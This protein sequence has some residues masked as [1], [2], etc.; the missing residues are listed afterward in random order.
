MLGTIN[1]DLLLVGLQIINVGLSGCANLG[2]TSNIDTVDLVF[3]IRSIAG[4]LSSVILVED[5]DF[6]PDVLN[7][8]VA[9]EGC[10]SYCR[11][12]LAV[13]TRSNLD[14][15]SLIQVQGISITLER[16][17][18]S[19]GLVLVFQQGDLVAVFAN[20][21]VA[22]IDLRG[23][24]AAGAGNQSGDILHFVG[25]QSIPNHLSCTVTGQSYAGINIGQAGIQALLG[26][27][28]VDLGLPEIVANI[29]LDACVVAQ[30][31]QQHLCCLGAGDVAVGVETTAANAANDSL[32]HAVL[33][34][35]CGPVFLG[36]IVEC[37]NQTAA[38]VRL[39]AAVQSD[40]D[41]LAHFSAGDVTG[42][43]EGPVLVAADDVQC[44][45]NINGLFVRDRFL[46][47]ERRCP[48]THDHDR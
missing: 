10:C 47:P 40:A 15:S 25:V 30:D 22:H 1:F 7:V 20:D 41:H 8:Y 37:A 17:H 4:A 43:T 19:A 33:N 46:I 9:G 36:D 28:D 48:R 12:T 45:T 21:L 5:F 34:V 3:D 31:A 32:A 16:A 14:V 23:Q 26:S 11:S 35:R 27:I 38:H 6:F 29:A 18:I 24:G 42:R 39:L 2:S 44:S 13:F